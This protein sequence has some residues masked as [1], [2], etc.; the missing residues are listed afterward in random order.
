M[1]G[2]FADE[3]VAQAVI[4]GLIGRGFDV[5][6]AKAVCRGET[7]MRVLSLAA[8]AGRV[9][10]TEDWGFGE[11]TI[12]HGA[13]AAGVIILSLFALSTGRREAHAVEKI[14]SLADASVGRLTIIEPGRIRPL[15]AE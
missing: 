13:P 1:P 10:I 4:E 7:D 12:R 3:C 15:A 11:M 2:F 14:A 6:D 8:A 9:V 5:L